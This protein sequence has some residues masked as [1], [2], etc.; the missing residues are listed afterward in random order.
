MAAGALKSAKFSD[1]HQKEK[2]GKRLHL[3]FTCKVQT[4]CT[5]KH[6]GGAVQSTILVKSK[7][8]VPPLKSY[9]L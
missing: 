8:L 4:S 1:N 7:S 2:N 6:I 5:V 3:S 9:L